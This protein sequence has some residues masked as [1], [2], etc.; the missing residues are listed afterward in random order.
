MQHTKKQ[1]AKYALNQ[2]LD[3]TEL[4]E[5]YDNLNLYEKLTDKGEQ[6]FLHHLSKAAAKQC[7]VL[8]GENLRPFT[9]I[10]TFLISA[11][12]NTLTSVIQEGLVRF[13]LQK[14]KTSEV[15]GYRILPVTSIPALILQ[16]T[17]QANI[18]AHLAY[19][20]FAN[21]QPQQMDS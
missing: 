4:S 5:V 13:T 6:K 20:Y 3:N 10:E 18:V 14:N 1:L 8:D 15:I 21:T 19:I 11:T 17:L 9:D 7:L 2:L 12:G 16:N